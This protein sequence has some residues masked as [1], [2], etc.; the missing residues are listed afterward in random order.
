V[1]TIGVHSTAARAHSVVVVWRQGDVAPLL[2]QIVP[3]LAP[4]QP[5]TATLTVAGDGSDLVLVYLDGQGRRLATTEA[6]PEQTPPVSQL[7]SLPPYITTTEATLAWGGNDDSAILHYDLQVRDGCD[8]DWTDWLTHTAQ[9]SGTY[10]GL[11]G[12]TYFFRVRARDVFGNVE[13]WLDDE[14]GD[15][16]TSVLVTP[17]PV[18]VTSVKEPSD[19]VRP[20]GRAVTYTLSLRNTGNLTAAARLTDTL[21]AVMTLLTGTLTATLGTPAFAGDR[22]AW[23][24]EV[25]AGGS[26]TVTYLLSPTAG[27]PL[28]T[29]ITNVVTFDDGVHAPFSRQAAVRY[30]YLAWLPLVV[31][32]AAP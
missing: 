28:L 3:L 9:V 23:Q 30:A 22:I 31:K 2:H 19:A 15:A 5:Y 16:F 29:P 32:S 21:P 17:A 4:A 10:A 26:V 20:P 12:H 18:L 24:G 11:D 7:S 8:G 14:W 1:V 13:S 27:A 6:S 25:A